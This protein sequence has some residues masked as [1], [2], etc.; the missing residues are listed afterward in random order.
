MFFSVLLVA[1]ICP[2]EGTVK[3]GIE[4][5]IAP[6]DRMEI[7]PNLWLVAFPG[8][9]NELLERLK[10]SDGNDGSPFVM[11]AKQISGHC[12]KDIVRW[13][14]GHGWNNQHDEPSTEES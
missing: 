11:E 10:V 14:E 12:S 3:P 4:Q 5:K 13:F 6:C 1:D 2:D 8:S 9:A 7:R